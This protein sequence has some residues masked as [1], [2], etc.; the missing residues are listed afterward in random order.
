MTPSEGLPPLACTQR[1][2]FKCMSDFPGVLEE[3]NM[4]N[5]MHCSKL[6]FANPSTSSL[7]RRTSFRERGLPRCYLRLTSHRKIFLLLKTT[8][9]S[10]GFACY[11]DYERQARARQSGWLPLVWTSTSRLEPNFMPITPCRIVP[12]QKPINITH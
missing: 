1:P 12:N 7:N 2:L 4:E 10:D 8:G 3:I 6:E 5:V 9:E 11:E